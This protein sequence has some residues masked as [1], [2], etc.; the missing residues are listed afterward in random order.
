MVR[1]ATLPLRASC[2]S[3]WNGFPRSAADRHTK[4]ETRRNSTI[5]VFVIIDF[6]IVNNY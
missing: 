4:Q 3:L 5:N 1:V 6:N 2:E